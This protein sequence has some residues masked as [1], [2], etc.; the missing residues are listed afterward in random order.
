MP[1]IDRNESRPYAFISYS[2][3]DKAQV[4]RIIGTFDNHNRRYWYDRGIRHGDDWEETINNSLKNSSVFILFVTN[5]IEQRPEIIRE[6]RM[7]IKKRKE[8]EY[9]IFMILL[10]RVNIL[11]M[12]RDHEDIAELCSKVQYICASDHGGFTIDFFQRMLSYDI[13]QY[14]ATESEKEQLL[15]EDGET[16]LSLLEDVIS[17]TGYIYPNAYPQSRTVNG[18]SFYTINVGETDPNAVYPI[19]MDNQWYPEEFNDDETFRKE[20]FKNQKL[21]DQRTAMQQYEVLSALLHNWQVVINRASIFNTSA[22]A[23]WFYDETDRKAFC[24]LLKNG[25]FIVYLMNE[26]SPAEKPANFSVLSKQFEAWSKICDETAVYCIRM[27]WDD[28][29]NRFET[30]RKLSQQMMDLLLTTAN[31]PYRLETFCGAMGI[32]E[33]K[34]QDFK[35]LWRNIRDKT[36]ENDD[37]PDGR[38][39]RNSVYEDFLIKEGT[40]V[41]ECI[42]DYDKP[43]VCELKQIVDFKY[44]IN[45]PAALHISPRSSYENRLWDYEMSERRGFQQ[46]RVITAEELYCAVVSFMPDFL[47]ELP[48][49]ISDNVSL[50]DIVRIRQLPEW[51]AYMETLTASR[52]R[53]N[54]NQVDYRDVEMI[55]KRYHALLCACRDSLGELKFENAPAELSIVYH[56]GNSNIISVYR[57]GDEHIRIV[58]ENEAGLSDKPRENVMIEFAFGDILRRS[59]AANCFIEKLRLFEGILLQSGRTGFEKIYEALT[60]R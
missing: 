32:P 11:H 56:V 45:L 5:G 22:L 48:Y 20:G 36:I 6:I 60:W 31:D 10:E 49:L 46:M 8:G 29:A 37:K 28:D 34:R 52:K 13:W 58:K 19:C 24:E 33:D 2:H 40:E 55:W 15:K 57:Q 1:I 38:Y 27:S 54:L 9:K 12:F 4:E 44:T 7:A 18:V 59:A 3:S 50:S 35:L 14:C 43:F 26:S 17:H 23:E 39:T 16:G 41:P 25:S 42:L 51:T 30:S 53:A 47:E 21:N